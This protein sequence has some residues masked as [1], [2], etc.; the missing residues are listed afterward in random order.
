MHPQGWEGEDRVKTL[1]NLGSHPA[2]PQPPPQAG[3]VAP[4]SVS[5]SARQGVCVMALRPRMAW[6]CGGGAG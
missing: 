1:K 4:G 6:E 3:F 5:V 2:F